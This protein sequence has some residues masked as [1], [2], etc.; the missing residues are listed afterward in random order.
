MMREARRTLTNGILRG[1]LFVFCALPQAHAQAA[2]DLL[3]STRQRLSALRICLYGDD[4]VVQLSQ[5][6]MGG[7]TAGKASGG[8]YGGGGY[9]GGAGGG[10]YKSPSPLPPPADYLAS[11]DRD[12]KA[13]Q[14]SAKVKDPDERKALLDSVR[15]D[16]HIKAQDCRK[17]G[18]GR[19]VTVR[20]MTLKGPVADN[21]WEVFYRW[22]CASAFQPAEI[23]VP[24]LTS[25]ATLKLPPGNYTVR[26]QKK[27]SDTQLLNTSTV[28]VVIG[29]QSGS[30]I[31][32]PVQ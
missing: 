13:C 23:R 25:P 19:M 29:L 11:L 22:Q 3:D 6:L 18:M 24:Q 8:G 20:V 27:V 16:I 4:E 32:L 21:G 14:F 5:G 15:E 28:S 12:I 26:A 9:G 2:F 17:F 30:D 31:Q 7:Y 10:G 1:L